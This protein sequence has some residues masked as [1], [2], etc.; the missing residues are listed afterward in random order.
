MEGS[1][2]AGLLEQ[3][4]H[5]EAQMAAV[6]GQGALDP[7]LA[8]RYPVATFA[9][10][11]AEAAEWLRRREALA[12]G[13]EPVVP[14]RG[15]R[16]GEDDAL[17]MVADRTA[18]LRSRLFEPFTSAVDRFSGATERWREVE[19]IVREPMDTASTYSRWRDERLGID[20][21][22]SGD[23]FARRDAARADREVERPRPRSRPRPPAEGAGDDDH[24]QRRDERRERR[25]RGGDDD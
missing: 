19:R 12:S 2:L 25:R 22:G 20:T 16:P 17:A 9:Q 4:R 6:T 14:G 8:A 5:L 24:L 3:R 7:A 11:R 1:P 21:G 18:P 23:V 13:R 15:A 10:R